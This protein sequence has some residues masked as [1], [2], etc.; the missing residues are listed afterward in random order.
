[1]SFGELPFFVYGT[2]RPQEDNYHLLAGQTVK[3]ISAHIVGFRLYSLGAYPMIIR[4]NHLE[5]VVQGVVVWVKPEVYSEVQKKLDWLEEYDPDDPQSPYQRMPETVILNPSTESLTA[6]VYVG[7]PD[8]L[9]RVSHHLIGG[10]DWAY[11]RHGYHI[12]GIS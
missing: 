7:Q 2:L 4:T 1:M 5:H 9:R 12:T 10:G 3:E 6:W 11:Y 8:F